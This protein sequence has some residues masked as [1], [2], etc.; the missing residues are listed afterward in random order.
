MVSVANEVFETTLKT[1]L[2]EAPRGYLLNPQITASLQAGLENLNNHPQLEWLNSADFEAGSMTPPNAVFK[3]SGRSFFADKSLSKE[4]FGPV[5]L[6]VE[7]EDE[8]QMMEVAESL[9][10]LL[11]DALKNENPLGIYRLVNGGMTRTCI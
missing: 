8:T 11:P 1:K 7:C 9:N 6:Y 3:T 10:A 2:S 4:V 5:T